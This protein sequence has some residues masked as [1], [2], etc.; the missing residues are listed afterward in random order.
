[1]S[2]L[3]MITERD[4]YYGVVLRQ[5]TKSG[6]RVSDLREVG[7]KAGHFHINE[8]A[9]LLVKYSSKDQSPWR[10]CFHPSDF[11]VLLESH[12]RG[13]LFGGSYVCLVCGFDS[14][15]LLHE[16]DWSVLLSMSCT[17]RQQTIMVRRDAGR[18]FIVSGTAGRLDYKVSLSRFPSSLFT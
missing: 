18:S 7:D 17:D 2:I 16:D 3:L 12:H 8:E 9:F 10:F 15:C 1:M 6:H 11:P 13:G 5:L 14:I 4:K